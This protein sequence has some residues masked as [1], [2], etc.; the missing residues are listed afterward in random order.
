[1]GDL[2]DSYDE[3]E[4]WTLWWFH[5][6]WYDEMRNPCINLDLLFHWDVWW[7]VENLHI[8]WRYPQWNKKMCTSLGSKMP[9]MRSESFH[10]DWFFDQDVA[11]KLAFNN[12][13]YVMNQWPLLAGHEKMFGKRVNDLLKVIWSNLLKKQSLIQWLIQPFVNCKSMTLEW[14][15]QGKTNRFVKLQTFLLIIS[16]SRDT[17]E[18]RSDREC[19]QWVE[20]LGWYVPPKT[21]CC[22]RS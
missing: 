6:H 16:P 2:A 17:L 3:K 7:N 10:R 5:W 13:E 21:Q 19:M 18:S 15:S 11:K 12:E 8:L 22:C 14:R 4:C 9:N 20:Q 1:M